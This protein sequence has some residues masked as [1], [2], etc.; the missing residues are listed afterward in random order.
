M[1]QNLFW[2]YIIDEKIKRQEASTSA[3]V[4]DAQTVRANSRKFE[5]KTKRIITGNCYCAA[6]ALEIRYHE[7]CYAH[8]VSVRRDS[9]NPAHPPSP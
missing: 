2:N 7:I 4:S 6:A 9:G 3:G 8:Y 1:A 5:E